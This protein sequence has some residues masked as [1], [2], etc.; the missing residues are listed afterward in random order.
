MIWLDHFFGHQLAT[1]M[2]DLPRYTQVKAF[3]REKILA[4]R[5]LKSR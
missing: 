3:K 1:F 4:I 5:V 2:L